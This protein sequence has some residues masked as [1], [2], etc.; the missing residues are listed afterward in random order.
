MCNYKDKTEMIDKINV[1]LRDKG[2]ICY[3]LPLF[4]DEE[5]LGRKLPDGFRDTILNCSRGLSWCWSSS[6]SSI[7]KEKMDQYTK[8]FSDI[9]ALSLGAI[10]RKF[11]S[12]LFIWEYICPDCFRCMTRHGLSEKQGSQANQETE[13]SATILESQFSRPM[14]IL[15]E[16]TFPTFLK[17]LEAD[18]PDGIVYWHIDLILIGVD[19]GREDWIIGE[20][21]HL[22]RAVE[23]FRTLE[24]GPIQIIILINVYD[25]PESFVFVPHI[26][27]RPVQ[28]MLESWNVCQANLKKW[29]YGWGMPS[30]EDYFL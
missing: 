9:P 27:I 6:G 13:N 3:G 7:S 1:Y 15:R 18:D 4:E 12:V 11:L 21:S 2:V 10:V 30:L 8:N 5:S 19:A 14:T 17:D 23:Q 16:N 25:T 26:P 28:E 29:R 24:I 20:N 22:K